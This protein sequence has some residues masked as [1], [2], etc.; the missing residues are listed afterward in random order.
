MSISKLR[1][2]DYAD[3][4]DDD[5]C[6]AV[7]EV[8]LNNE[9]ITNNKDN[10]SSS[11]AKLTSSASEGSLLREIKKKLGHT[12]RRKSED[13]T[14]KTNSTNDPGEMVASG[15][16]C[17]DCI[18]RDADLRRLENE[19]AGLKRE[20]EQ[21][22]FE[23]TELG[24][25]LADAE[26]ML[27]EKDEAL[28]SLE[29]TLSLA[30]EGRAALDADLRRKTDEC[31][32]LLESL[33]KMST[34]S[35]EKQKEQENLI[36]NLRSELSDKNKELE[37]HQQE[38]EKNEKEISELNAAHVA[39]KEIAAS[40]QSTASSL[41][42]ELNRIAS[43]RDEL[44]IKVEN[45]SQELE[46]S[47]KAS[48]T[49][50]A[51]EVEGLKQETHSLKQ[52]IQE[53][54]RT[55]Q[56]AEADF[57]AIQASQN[58]FAEIL[59][60][61]VEEL[62]KEKS[63]WLA[64]RDSYEEQI[65][66]YKIELCAAYDDAR[67]RTSGPQ[68]KD[69]ELNFEIAELK[70][71]NEN[72]SQLIDNLKCKI[73]QFEAEKLDMSLEKT[74]YKTQI[75][76]LK[77]EKAEAELRVETLEQQEGELLAKIKSL[78]EAKEE[79][80]E[81]VDSLTREVEQLRQE[82]NAW[83][84]EKTRINSQL[85]EL[86]KSV[87]SARDF[88]KE[89]SDFNDR[90][91]E[92]NKEKSELSLQLQE[93]VDSLAV[94]QKRISSLEST[95]NDLQNDHAK[96]L[97]QLRTASARSEESSLEKERRVEQLQFDYD[98]AMEKVRTLMD[99]K[100]AGDAEVLRLQEELSRKQNELVSLRIKEANTAALYND[101]KYKI[102]TVEKTKEIETAPLEIRK[103]AVLMESEE[104]VDNVPN[105]STR[106]SSPRRSPDTYEEY[107]CEDCNT[108]GEHATENCPFRVQ[109]TEKVSYTSKEFCEFCAEYGHDTFACSS[110]NAR[111]KRA[112][113]VK[114]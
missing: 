33:E 91:D 16:K 14:I 106:S 28:K 44:K 7:Y 83:D 64:E 90:I 65:K 6:S 2:E 3:F 21:L 52:K 55:H 92:L 84:E 56:L 48:A 77:E 37:N 27:Y 22:T 11:S 81:K 101:A 40:L 99:E 94:L 102:T 1:D 34:S 89:R 58:E 45:L 108:F 72:Q 114:L 71:A 4:D 69:D 10:G 13:T 12:L 18:R 42:E 100:A 109:T 75:E 59:N 112:R 73:D 60:K 50:N 88:D 67:Y 95:M 87:T 63:E 46:E 105:V 85:Q 17:Q 31:L 110:Y 62:K 41:T 15:V 57:T 79:Y 68:A 103:S 47:K 61:R 35:K 51:E 78:S 32:S 53:M 86:E 25:N 36:E 30:Q 23:S 96:E 49:F 26:T 111:S 104:E 8:P 29:L 98:E 19:V 97:E 38:L 5:E 76:E 70:K 82:K 66:G 9:E 20:V 74:K 93:A 24:T 107:Y 54:E 80:G 43:E 113:N 39:T